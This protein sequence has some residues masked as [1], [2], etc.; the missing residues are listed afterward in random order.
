MLK[1]PSTFFSKAQQEHWVSFSIIQA[2][3]S[4][5]LILK[6]VYEFILKLQGKTSSRFLLTH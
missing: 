6:L 4:E 2:V 5:P 1:V 3:M